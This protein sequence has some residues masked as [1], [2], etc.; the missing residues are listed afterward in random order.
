MEGKVLLPLILGTLNDKT[1]QF[2]VDTHI[3]IEMPCY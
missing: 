3:Q 1:R 2:I